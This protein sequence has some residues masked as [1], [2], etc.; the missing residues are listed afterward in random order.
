MKDKKE[1]LDIVFWTV[2]F[3]LIMGGILNVIFKINKS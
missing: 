2:V 3:F 1:A